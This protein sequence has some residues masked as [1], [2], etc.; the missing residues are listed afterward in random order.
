MSNECRPLAEQMSQTFRIGEIADRTGL[1]IH[2]LRWYEAQ[3][4]VPG[5]LRD[6]GGRRV[7]SELHLGWIDL[8]DRLRATGM[9]IAEIRQYTA[10]VKQGNGTL[11]PRRAM[12]A[13]HRVRVKARIEEWAQALEL[14]D[15]K[16]DFYERWLATGRRPD[17]ALQ[18]RLRRSP[19]KRRSA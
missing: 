13:A 12:L 5:V 17:I 7:Y 14:I 9:S 4:L 11:K 2:A 15:Y 18:P 1:S 6:Q 8:V 19:K 16:I 3:G 10:L